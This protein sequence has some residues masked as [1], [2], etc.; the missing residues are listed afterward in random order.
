MKI[1]L[2]GMP[3]AGKSTV[4]R[5]LA[6][7]LRLRFEDTDARIEQDFGPI[8]RIFAERGEE[9]FRAIETETLRRL[10]EEDGF[11]LATGGGIVTREENR[12]LLKGEKTVWLD[13]SVETLCSRLEGDNTRPLLQGGLCERLL[14]LQAARGS[15]YAEVG[16]RIVTDGLSPQEVVRILQEEI[17]G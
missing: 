16:R 4:G 6:A 13:A 2:C 11:V 10:L 9:G 15:L 12:A 14:A 8:P 17:L 7:N 3:G 5:L 1:V